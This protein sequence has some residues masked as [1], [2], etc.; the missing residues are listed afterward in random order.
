MEQDFNTLWAIGHAVV[1]GLNPYSVPNS[2]Y[3]PAALYFLAILGLFPKLV[4]FILLTVGNLSALMLM[5]ANKALPHRS[6]AWVLFTPVIYTLGV[7]QID[8]LFL[9]LFYLTAHRKTWV[10][11]LA[12]VL[13]TLKP[14]LAFVALPWTL[15]LW[16]RQDRKKLL[17][18]MGISLVLHLTPLLLNGA[19]YSEWLAS[20]QG[21]T[22][23][24]MEDTPGVFSLTMAGVPFWV[25]ILP[26]LA[27]MLIGLKLGKV[28]S[29]VAQTL[30]LPFG[31]WYNLVLLVGY[32]P[33]KLLV[34]LSW[35]AF[36]LSYFVFHAF[37]P[38]TL[39][40]LGAAIWL[41]WKRSR[42]LPFQSLEKGLS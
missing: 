40:P 14:Q 7:G 38:M 16:L 1:T 4:A 26:A 41:Y 11:I 35:A 34:P 18:W 10:C 2:F 29:L 23:M 21:M 12:A 24:Y 33:W 25:M 6:I 20:V 42:P 19:I 30:A 39:V 8:L 37:Y 22:K 15:F 32:L 5:L 9:G 3:P 27:I 17:L 13:L 36:I 31:Y 28:E